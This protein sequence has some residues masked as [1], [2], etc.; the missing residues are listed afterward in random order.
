MDLT[1][2]FSTAYLFE[3]FPVGGFSWIFRIILLALFIGAIVIAILGQKKLK[4]SGPIKKF[5]QKM[6]LWGW[7]TGLIGLLLVLFR[8]LRAIYLSAR[9][10]LFLW[11]VISFLW[12]V[13]NI[14]YL[15]RK[16]PAKEEIIK[17]QAEFNRWLP[18]QK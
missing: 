8:E 2:L 1:K 4:N 17:K 9:F 14:I 18:K 10:W 11:L 12:L 3:R 6:I 13:F 16:V 15:K 5:W 7:T